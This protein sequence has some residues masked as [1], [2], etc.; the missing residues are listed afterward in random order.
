MSTEKRNTF[1]PGWTREKCR[2]A[3]SAKDSSPPVFSLKRW[4]QSHDL[5]QN[6]RL[7]KQGTAQSELNWTPSAGGP[8]LGARPGGKDLLGKNHEAPSI[9]W[10]GRAI[11][12]RNADCGIRNYNRGSKEFRIPN[13]GT[14]DEPAAFCG[15]R[16]KSPRKG[17]TRPMLFAQ[18]L[19]APGPQP[20]HPAA[21][22]PATSGTPGRSG[23]LPEWN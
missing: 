18:K 17:P 12:I 11:Q 5:R 22:N 7:E 9:S 23:D 8:Q 1:L 16:V 15:S 14:P 4:G 2:S 3:I 20:K 10:T 19:L 6:R 21:V 13:W